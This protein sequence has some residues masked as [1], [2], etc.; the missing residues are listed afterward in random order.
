METTHNDE[1][2]LT[3][4]IWSDAHK[5]YYGFRPKVIGKNW[6]TIEEMEADMDRWMRYAKLEAKMEAEWE[7]EYQ[8]ELAFKARME[9]PEDTA[10]D[11]LCNI[12]DKLLTE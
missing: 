11:M 10:Y 4:G 7:K 6:M 5:D 8:E 3:F 2:E 12:E 1:F 9:A